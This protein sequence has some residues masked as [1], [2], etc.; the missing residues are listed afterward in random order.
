[1]SLL[2]GGTGGGA[3]GLFGGQCGTVVMCQ[4]R[5]CMQALSA[6]R[7]T[8]GYPVHG[9]ASPEVRSII[10]VL[11]HRCKLFYKEKPVQKY[12]MQKH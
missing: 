8:Q 7:G 10:H 9:R 5:E 4:Q 2:G 1:M 12:A 11:Y 6:G 3:V